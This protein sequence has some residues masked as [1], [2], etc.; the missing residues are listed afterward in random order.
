MLPFPLLILHCSG[1]WPGATEE[2]LP[3]LLICVCAFLIGMITSWGL[4]T[5]TYCTLAILSII[6]ACTFA[7]E[8]RISE[9]SPYT[10]NSGKGDVVVPLSSMTKTNRQ[11]DR[12]SKNPI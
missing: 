7:A 10:V 11:T 5:W 8:E 3:C 6:K 12:Q 2:K 4:K 9:Y 1:V